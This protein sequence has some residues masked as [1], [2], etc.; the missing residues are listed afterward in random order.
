MFH[1]IRQNHFDFGCLLFKFYVRGGFFGCFAVGTG[2]W[3]ERVI[4]SAL[5]FLWS[6]SCFSSAGSGLEINLS[7]INFLSIFLER[8]K[9]G[10][11]VG[12]I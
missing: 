2:L 5:I 8:G 10:G 3:P 4:E 12:Y 11:Q 9:V 1:C 7:R 6:L